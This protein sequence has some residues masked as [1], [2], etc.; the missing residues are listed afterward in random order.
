ML[1]GWTAIQGW[2]TGGDEAAP[3][4]QA[5]FFVDLEDLL[6]N[7]LPG[8]AL[9][10]RN[11]CRAHPTPAGRVVQQG[12]QC[13]RPG[14]RIARGQQQA[15]T[16]IADDLGEAGNRGGDHGNATGHRLEQHDAEALLAGRWGAE[17]VGTGVIAWQHRGV[18]ES[19]EVN[20]RDVVSSDVTP[21]SGTLR[22]VGDEHQAHI[23]AI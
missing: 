9:G 7:T 14:R 5:G 23:A 18:D 1:T 17:G 8:V 22:A 2:Q 20:V 3:L 15:L 6:G 16:T 10:S 19:P 21:E 4:P 13:P 11:A 12:S